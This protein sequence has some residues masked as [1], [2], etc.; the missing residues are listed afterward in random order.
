MWLFSGQGSV[1]VLRELPAGEQ[2]I[3]PAVPPEFQHEI[4]TWSV[5]AGKMVKLRQK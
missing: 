1:G 2:P 3:S 4:L 5:A